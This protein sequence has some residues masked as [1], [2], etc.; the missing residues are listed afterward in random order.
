MMPHRRSSF[1]AAGL[2]ALLASLPA[3]AAATVETRP[4][5]SAGTLAPGFTRMPATAAGIGF[6]NVLSDERSITNRNLLSGSGVALGDVDSDG[7]PDL[8]LS[9]ADVPPALY[10]NLGGWTFAD[11]SAAA[12]PGIDWR[13]PTSGS[14]DMTGAAFADVD[15]DGDVDLFLN[16][17]G[18]GTR[19][20]RNDGQGRFAESTD[21][22][23]LRSRHGATSL[24]LA[25]VDGDGDL[26][27]YVA[28]FRPVTILDQP[29]T[30]YQMRQTPQGPVI[31]AVN[32]RPVTAPDLT[33]RFELGPGGDVAELGEADALFLN[34]GRGVFAEVPW[35]GGAFVDESGRPLTSPPGDWGLAARFQDMDG[36]GRPD[37]YVCND[38]QTPDRVWMNA[39]GPDR[40]PRF[41]ALSPIALRNNPTFSMGVDFGDFN[42]DGHV[43]FFA[44]DM[45]S[46]NRAWRHTQMAGL[47]PTL[48]LPGQFATRAQV[49]RN[50]LQIQRGDGTWADTAWQAGVAA[51]EWSWGPV[52][53]DV[54]LDGFEDLIVPNGQ[55]RDFQDGD[56]TRRI[57]DAA[58]AGQASTPAQVAALVRTVP[59]LATP[60]VAFRNR[61]DATFDDVSA[62]WGFTADTVSQG[63]ALGDIDGD[64]D[65]DVVMNDLSDAP[66]LYRNNSTAPRVRIGLRGPSPNRAGIGARITVRAAGL[67][68]QT[69]EVFAGGRYLG[70]DA[71][72]RTFA[73]G[74]ATKVDIEVRWPGGAVESLS[75]VAAGTAVTVVA[76][77]PLPPAPRNPEPAKPT[78][79][80][81][82]ARLGHVHVDEP[83]D[84]FARQPTLPLRLSQA[85]PGVTWTDLDGNGHPDLVVGAGRGGRP[86]AF[87]NDGR[88]G[89]SA[90]DRPPFQKPTGR[91]LTAL[92]PLN[93]ALVAGVSN[94][95]DGLTNGGALRLYDPASGRSGEMLVGSAFGTGPL[96]AA[97]VDGDGELE[98]FVGSRTVPGRYP[99]SDPSLLLRNQGGRLVVAER[100]GSLG[101][102]TAACFTDLDGDGRPDLVVA[103]DW[104]APRFFR[105]EAGRLKPWEPRFDWNRGGG[106]RGAWSSVTAGDFDE[107]GRLD[108]VLGNE[109]TNRRQVGTTASPRRLYAGDF[110]SGGGND[111]VEAWHDPVGNVDRPE[112]EFMMMT[113]LFPAVR[114]AVTSYR[115]YSTSSVPSLFGEL[116]TRAIRLEIDTQ[117]SVVLLNR[118]D[119]FEVRPLPAAAQ[120]STVQGLC[121][122]DYDGDG[123][124]DLFVAQNDSTAH[125]FAERSDAGRGL[126][127]HGNGSGGF[128]ADFLSGVAVHGDGRGAAVADFDADGRI[129]LAVGQNGA[130]TTLWRNV[131]GK[132]GLRVRL[133]GPAGNPAAIGAAVRVL[134]GGK[135]G[136]WREL[137]LGSGH[138]S[139]DD[140]TTVLGRPEGT[141]AVEVRWPGGK[142]AR[143]PI[144]KNAN[145]LR[146]RP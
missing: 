70:G 39:T 58:A 140:P 35:T 109:G 101:M 40:K 25:D 15:G 20:F 65:L 138:L 64:G 122:A 146:L 54:D 79:E 116:A 95:E 145:D 48:R 57:A 51:S 130:A 1:R 60:N 113:A 118:G 104:G 22:A 123:H 61:G 47:A 111:L 102:A 143:H 90:M 115:A 125:P 44:V 107:D 31:V 137:H 91:D 73:A 45:F 12:F 42:R 136:P 24:A 93:G 142:V 7:R 135:T 14:F 34:D 9:G 26:D 117:E 53:L 106:L 11:V 103:V 63:V 72:E 87:L 82:S 2:V 6:T 96:A 121:V 33:N 32:G 52:S 144:P 19:L 30:R 92:L 94:F 124:D 50:V 66:G 97:D 55:R 81:V 36:D 84:D 77:A 4:F 59:S 16:A 89:F 21:A 119:R 75:G 112:R 17:L 127:L 129:D 76:G 10:R 5:A 29:N 78:F 126:W 28:R 62:T 46:R 110:G 100:L 131:G 37:L 120:W 114:D 69:T 56:A 18:G 99:D 128:R 27:L 49:Q 98:V 3:A 139:C 67:P 88:G 38:L 141:E 132:P 134:G 80:D 71:P 43:D 83:F 86:A 23:G 68:A 8:L 85:G 108:V 41:K 105:N 74:T 13:N 133:E